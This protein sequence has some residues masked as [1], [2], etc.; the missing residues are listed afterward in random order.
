MDLRAHTLYR[1]LKALL[2]NHASTASEKEKAR[3]RMD[4][5]LADHGP[6][7]DDTAEFVVEEV[8][9]PYHVQLFVHSCSTHGLLPVPGVKKL[10]VRG[11]AEFVNRVRDDY[12][13]YAVRL[14]DVLMLATFS[15]LQGWGIYHDAGVPGAR[16]DKPSFHID[17]RPWVERAQQ[18]IQQI[19][20]YYRRA[21][22]TLRQLPAR[23]DTSGEPS[24]NRQLRR[25]NSWL[26]LLTD[27]EYK[28]EF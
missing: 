19:A 13:A 25:F 1:K 6:E 27:G 23:G 11:P 12:N 24:E 9:S 28:I 17:L 16:P 18:S 20:V 3:A 2:D 15:E 22:L 7:I 21:D 10:T 5:L 8:A 14:H 4:K 26:G